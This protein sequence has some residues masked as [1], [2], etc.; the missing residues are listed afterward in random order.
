MY[1]STPLR[2]V[3]EMLSATENADCE[4]EVEEKT[5]DKTSCEDEPWLNEIE[6]RFEAIVSPIIEEYERIDAFNRV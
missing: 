5:S 1:V 3:F 4:F 2:T 6:V